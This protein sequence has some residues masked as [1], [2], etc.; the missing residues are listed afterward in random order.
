MT[1]ERWQKLKHIFYSALSRAPEER[2]KFLASACG[3]DEMLRQEVES[4]LASNEKGGSFMDAPAYKAVA[5]LAVEK[6]DLRAGETVASYEVLS[7]LSRGGRGEVYLGLD[8]RLGRKVALKFLRSSFTE[9]PDCLR[10]F[11]QEARAAS[12]LNHPNKFG[13]NNFTSGEIWSVSVAGT[14][15]NQLT[16]RVTPGGRQSDRWR[17]PVGG[18]ARF[19][20]YSHDGRNIY[21]V[22]E[23]KVWMLPISPVNNEPVADPAAISDVGASTIADLTLSADGRRMAY[24]VQSWAS[25]IWS[26]STTP[27]AYGALGT[28]KYL[29]N[30]TNTR[31]TQPAFSPDGRRLAFLQYLRGATPSLWLADADGRNPV[32]IAERVNLPNWFPD[33]DQIAFTSNRENHWSVWVISLQSRRER[34]I[35]DIGRDIQYAR[36]SPDGRQIVF[37]LADNGIINSWTVPTSGGQPKQLTFDQELAGFACWSPD[38]KFLAF[39]MKRGDNAYLMVMPSAGGDATQMTFGQ[40]RSWPHSFSP[41]GDKIVFAG[42][43]D[44]VWNLYWVSRTSKE[45]MQLTNYAKLNAYVRYPDWSPL[46]NQI[47]YEYSETTGNIWL[48][49]LK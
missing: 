1:P 4:L 11:E 10:R 21:F 30:Q 33:L 5:E 49:E 24:G 17:D 46:G 29:T 6:L 34:L 44:G 47:A 39:Q 36:L 38:G 48:L 32:Q 26:V 20:V 14:E 42:E 15:P 2:S 45:Q 8:R 16:H 37:N 18:R 28:P 13:T 9:D 22:S 23:S 3:E 41:D 27:D 40:G 7:F 12:S 43:R 25:N 19:P 35:F 31:N